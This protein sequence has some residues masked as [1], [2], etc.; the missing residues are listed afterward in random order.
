MANVYV[1]PNPDGDGWNVKLEG[2]DVVMASEATKEA[3]IEI[4]RT[5]KGDRG[6][7]RVQKKD[8]T[9]SDESE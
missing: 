1:V 7:L 9:F 5:M 6:N 3:A 2:S 4:G 8:G